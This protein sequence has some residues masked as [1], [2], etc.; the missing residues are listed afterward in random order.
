MTLRMGISVVFC[1]AGLLAVPGLGHAQGPGPSLSAVAADS[2]RGPVAIARQAHE[3]ALRLRQA[4]DPAAA[5]RTI[6]AALTALPPAPAGASP[7]VRA[8]LA[9][10]QQ[11]LSDL[12]DATQQDLRNLR[13]EPGN[14]ADDGVLN[15]QAID[16]LANVEAQD[17]ELVTKWMDFFM[18]AGRSTFERWLKRSGRYME[19]FR[20]VLQREGLPP[21]LVHLVFVESGFNVNARSVSA[22][23][24]PWQFLRSTGKVFG[25]TVDQWVDERKDPEKA[26]VAAARYLKHLY[27][28]FGDWPLAIASYNAGEG[29]VLRA[30]KAQGTTN[31][32]D[33]KLPRQ[34]EDYVPQFMAAMTIA[35]DPARYGFS[36]VELDDPMTFDEVALK[37]S[38]DLRALARLADCSFEELKALNPAVL[39]A[40]ARGAGGITTVRVPPG[41]GELLMQ[42][43]QGGERLPAVNVTLKHKVRRG[44]TLKSIARQY[45]IGARE[46]ARVNGIGKKRPL[47]RGMVLTVPSALRA[48]A[49]PQVVDPATDPRASTGYVP[50]R[51]LGLPARLDGHST[52]DGRTVVTVQRGETLAAIAERHGV[53]TQDL[54]RWNRLKSARVSRGMRLKVRTDEAVAAATPADSA[55]IA[56][57]K[58][59]RPVK[60]G[61]AAQRRPAHTVRAG[62]TLGGIARQHGVSVA[63]LK[64]ANGLSG[65]IIRKGQRLKLPT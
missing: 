52:T 9:G 35:R 48:S 33:L 39:H 20:S 49:A 59:P 15:A 51:K 34:T 63:A 26:T 42:R 44:E 2:A 22:A 28:I 40:A 32:W 60:R 11:R 57:L 62:E 61:A 47:R 43:L 5:L 55:Q 18:G 6:E 45:S 29:T 27:S 30:I 65:T 4:G 21:D 16:A 10:L 8:E 58:A 46:L 53:S 14:E 17:H 24:G 41:K 54:M 37:G 1:L 31:Y 38:V 13:V 23:V 12:Y 50:E 19:M 3:A 36:A 7:A 56:A 25:L 64:R